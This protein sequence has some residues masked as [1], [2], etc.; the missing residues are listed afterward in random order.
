MIDWTFRPQRRV[1]RGMVDAP[2]SPDRVIEP[3]CGRP[4]SKPMIFAYILL[5]LAI[6]SVVAGIILGIWCA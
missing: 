6:L 1:W 5:L 2:P 3:R 4:I